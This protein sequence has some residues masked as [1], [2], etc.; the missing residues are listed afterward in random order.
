MTSHPPPPLHFGIDIGGTFTDFVAFDPAAGQ[1]RTLKIL[2]T[3]AAPA[4]AVMAGLQAL[5]PGAD[6]DARVIHGSTVATNALLER[7]GAAVGF[8]A[9]R[10]FKDLLTI[11]R[12]NRAAAALYDFFGDRPAPLAPP[13]RCF[14]ISERV[15]CRGRVLQPLAAAEIPALVGALRAAGVEAV[16]ICLLFSFLHPEHEQRL[17]AALTAA[18][19]FVC[20]SSE[21]LPSFREYERGS[22]TLINAFVSPVMGRYL[23]QLGAHLPAASP[24]AREEEGAIPRLRIM[25]SNGGMIGVETAA[26]QAVRCI[27]SGPAGG[28]VGAR[29]VAQAAGYDRILAFDMGGTSTDASLLD[30][31]LPLTTEAEIAGL[32]VGVSLIDI[33]TVGA[34]GGSLAFVD[35]G[36]A[37]RV[38]PQSAGAAP[39]PACYGRGGQEAT[40]TDANLILGRIPADQFL[41]GRMSLDVAAA[42]AALTRLAHAARLPAHAHLTPAQCAALGVV[43][44]VNAHMERALRLISVE[45]GHDPA[46]FL[47]VSFGGAGGLHA[48]ALAR[49]LGIG[50]TLI[51]PQAAVLSALGMLAA[52]V[53]KDYVQTVMLAGA[54]LQDGAGLAARFAPL[55]AQ[56]EQDLATEGAPAARRQLLRQLDMRYVG[57]SYEITLPFGPDFSADF[58]AAHARA[59][60]YS[61]AT[62]AV[63]IVNLRVRAVGQV[64]PPPLPRRA[65][66][67]HAPLPILDRRPL[68]LADGAICS[69]PL[70][71]GDLLQPGQHLQGPALVLYPDTTLFL[72]PGDRAR[73]DEWGNLLIT[74]GDG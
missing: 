48:C 69:A 46:D 73:V 47:L 25:Q 5:A 38:G 31:G 62:A 54:D 18:G 49:S 6:A 14:E 1:F 24:A 43:R 65:L 15:D 72:G 55:L 21:I 45:R 35:A 4:Q 30:Q 58:H 52:D 37:L 27:L 71:A 68:V 44:V 74:V 23:H 66:A 39:G 3:P 59:Y 36:G 20:T 60:G 63:E 26:R 67:P 51:P 33:H 28:A 10:G 70:A 56:A 34:G 17:A 50:Q 42:D 13:E 7:K 64:Q 29:Y 22:T 32:P 2:S 16:A 53:V 19:F 12:Q 40:V 9:T 41:G 57:Q 61:T 11:G 8:V